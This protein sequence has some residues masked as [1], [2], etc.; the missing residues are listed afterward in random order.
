MM[1]DTEEAVAVDAQLPDDPY[2]PMQAGGD[3][4]QP[5]RNEVLVCRRCQTASLASHKFCP[6]CGEPLW[7]PC[8]HCGTVCPA[9]ER[10]CGLCGANLA[11]AI[12]Q[13]TE[14][15][16]M[17]LLT[18]ERLQAECRYD[19]AIAVLSP[20]SNL[21]H[22]RLGHHARL[23]GEF[24]KR[25]TAER[26]QGLGRA[27]EVCR[28]GQAR[29]DE[30]DYPG[31]I[32]LLEGIPKTLRSE[33]FQGLLTEASERQQ[34]LAFLGGELRAALQSKKIIAAAPKIAR[35]LELKPGHVQARQLAEQIQKRFAQAAEA[36][37][38]EF[39]Y[40]EAVKILAEVPKSLWNAETAALGSRANELA[41]IAWDLRN[42]AAVDRPLLAVAGRLRQ[43]APADPRPETRRRDAPPPH[44]GREGGPADPA[45]LG[46]GPTETPLGLPVDWLNGLGSIEPGDALDRVVVGANPGCFAV[47]CGLAL[48]GLG[49]SQVQLNLRIQ[50]QQNA[51]GKVAGLFRPKSA[52]VAWG[53]D[54]GSSGI[55]AVKL[56][57]Q[58]RRK[59]V[60]IEAAARVDYRKPL[61]QAANEE[62][63][64]GMIG[65]ALN[66][67]LAQHSLRTERVCVSV[68]GRI[69]LPR[70]FHL[71]AADH[72]KMSTMVQFE[73]KRHVPT[74]LDQLV[75]DFQVLAD[76][77]GNARTTTRSASKSGVAPVLFAAV[78]RRLLSKRL[79]VIRRS[80]IAIDVAQSECI[81]LHNFF[82][83][84]DAATAENGQPE[85][86]GDGKGDGD[87]DN[88]DSDGQ[89]DGV[90][91]VGRTESFQPRWPVMLVDVGGDGSNL[92]I[93][94]PS[95]LWV[96]HLGFGGYSITRAL[97]RQFNLTA[98]QAEELKRNPAAAPSLAEFYLAL[99]PVVEDFRREIGISLAAYAKME[100]SQPVRRMLGV[101]GGFQLHA[102]LAYLRSMP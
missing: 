78:R 31:A 84:Q 70:L 38:A 69:V 34:E 45:A 26:Q 8:V 17:N 58:K 7:E 102:L 74:R 72:A 19:E 57:W 51:I 65:E 91:G 23:A 55:K 81:A 64:S 63:E 99:E 67:L 79:D 101:G 14:Q 6:Q 18:A 36:K 53:L 90:G 62:E 27:E 95:G 89:I 52:S 44:P 3:A 40:E 66:G 5:H 22:P 1:N 49:Q 10:F 39:R 46:P 20:I 77:E 68:P 75:W 88:G 59:T 82:M 33:E 12:H 32:R 43:L 73:A 4:P 98:A 30:H 21:D 15:F 47:A 86:N 61:S 83:F 94:S 11:A 76:G 92:L 24:I 56:A 9:G 96:R 80:G 85:N 2:S 41:W 35:L 42:A 37:I 100:H 13:Q 29:F 97:V 87:S 60:T 48:Q 25:L 71:P 54:L 50:P 93:S 16:E 28:Q